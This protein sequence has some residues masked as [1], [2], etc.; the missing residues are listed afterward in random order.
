MHLPAEIIAQLSFLFQRQ[1]G[2][3]QLHLRILEG[4]LHLVHRGII[5][6]QEQGLGS[7]GDLGLHFLDKVVIDAIVGK[8][9]G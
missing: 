9:T 1:I 3:D 7:F 8:V 2:P 5:C 4:F 6:K